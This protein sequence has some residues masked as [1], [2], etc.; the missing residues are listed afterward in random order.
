M[1]N[2]KFNDKYIKYKKKYINLQRG[3]A[4]KPYKPY[5]NKNKADK[6]MY[7]NEA[8]RWFYWDLEEIHNPD[9]YF[10]PDSAPDIFNS[11]PP[12]YVKSGA[13]GELDT[14]FRPRGYLNN[15]DTLIYLKSINL[16]PFIEYYLWSYGYE[17]WGESQNIIE[18]IN[19]QDKKVDF[20]TTRTYDGKSRFTNRVAKKVQILDPEYEAERLAYEEREMVEDVLLQEQLRD[21]LRDG[22]VP[23]LP[24]DV[25][26]DNNFL[27]KYF[28]LNKNKN[29]IELGY[30]NHLISDRT[31][32]PESLL[33]ARINYCYNLYFSLNKYKIKIVS[34]DEYYIFSY[35]QLNR[36][37]TPSGLI[38]RINFS[39]L[40]TLFT[41]YNEHTPD[42]ELFYFKKFIYT[43]NN[44]D[45]RSGYLLNI[46][47]N[48]ETMPNITYTLE[49]IEKSS[50]TTYYSDGLGEQES[51]IPLYVRVR[52]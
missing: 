2:L 15:S 11:H 25:Y 1:L 41:R 50:P 35:N 47:Q 7:Q 17:S 18:Y 22:Y 12:E 40:L 30:Y 49:F 3:S 14:H 26:S 37:G 45:N 10:F 36:L 16:D 9:N 34:T 31:A 43:I 4:S 28:T 24:E 5:T 20:K 27:K 39:E 19:V 21:L 13:H 33:H 42:N 46:T 8:G 32:H 44:D 51:K 29:I 38:K 48:V 52:N 6:R 23:I